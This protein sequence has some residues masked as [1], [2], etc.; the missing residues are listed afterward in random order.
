MTKLTRHAI[1]I[2]AMQALFAQ[3]FDAGLSKEKAIQTALTLDEASVKDNILTPE[4]LDVLVSG[5]IDH[6]SELE[7]EIKKH[8]KRGWQL[9]RLPKIDRLILS[10][11]IFEIKY[12]DIDDKVAINE[13]VELA[14]EFGEDSASSFVNGVLKQVLNK[15]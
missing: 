5:V 1:R 6:Q 7:S 8:L 13:A 2:K 10:I 9:S 15:A 12:I 11:A 4:Y 14:K 3:D